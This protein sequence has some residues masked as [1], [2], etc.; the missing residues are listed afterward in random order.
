MRIELDQDPEVGSVLVVS[1]GT[2]RWEYHPAQHQYFKLASIDGGS[3]P[4][5]L[6]VGVSLSSGAAF[7]SP[8]FFSPSIVSSV[9][10]RYVGDAVVNGEKCFRLDFTSK[11]DHHLDSYSHDTS[12]LVRRELFE[13]TGTSFM[14]I[15]ELVE[16]PH[17]QDSIFKFTPP[18]EAHLEKLPHGSPNMPSMTG[19]SAPSF[20]GSDQYGH[21]ATLNDY[22]GRVL[23]LAFWATWC[24]PCRSELEM[25]AGFQPQAP[26]KCDILLVNEETNLDAV[27]SFLEFKHYNFRTLLS[28]DAVFD[29]YS[30]YA[31]PELVVVTPDQKIAHVFYGPPTQSHLVDLVRQ[32]ASGEA[33]ISPPR[34]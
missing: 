23:L 5:P 1:D 17:F 8:Y 9:D 4:M 13:P 31:L 6:V 3:N 33:P 15:S 26:P 27:H 30:T 25:L 2:A 22:K 16:S 28:A 14:T 18:A 24:A 11:Y 20:K 10:Y 29:S 21:E 7:F 12:M 19:H 34:P 32:L